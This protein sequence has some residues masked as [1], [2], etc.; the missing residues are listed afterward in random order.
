MEIQLEKVVSIWVSVSESPFAVP[1]E[2]VT[3]VKL[4]KQ[5]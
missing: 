2:P 4:E 1:I 3:S 5:D